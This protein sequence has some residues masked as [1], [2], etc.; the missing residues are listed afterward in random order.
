MEG[1]EPKGPSCSESCGFCQERCVR[2]R[3]L[4][5]GLLLQQ[6]LALCFC[7]EHGYL[8]PTLSNED[9]RKQ[10]MPQLNLDGKKHLPAFVFACEKVSLCSS[11]E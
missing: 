1:Y 5:P 11:Q 9:L 8:P 7:R 3:P 4:Q 10:I 6:P 2:L